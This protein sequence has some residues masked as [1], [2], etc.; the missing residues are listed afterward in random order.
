MRNVFLKPTRFVSALQEEGVRIR[1]GDALGVASIQTLQAEL[2]LQ[3]VKDRNERRDIATALSG[4][5]IGKRFNGIQITQ[6]PDGQEVMYRSD[7]SIEEVMGRHE[8]Y[9][10]LLDATIAEKRRPAR[11]KEEAER[12]RRQN[13]KGQSARQEI[14]YQEKANILLLKI[15]RWQS[16]LHPS[17][18]I[19]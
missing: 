16:E 5:V 12:Q 11:E 18:R 17:R 3:G 19:H 4:G 1:E 14:E 13:E 2:E 8:V 10:R 9:K 7:L 6:L 15:C